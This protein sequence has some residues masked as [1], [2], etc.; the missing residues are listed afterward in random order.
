M[1][2]WVGSRKLYRPDL[3]TDAVRAY[4]CS[5]TFGAGGK[6]V[7]DFYAKLRALRYS[8]F[9][10][11]DFEETGWGEL[12]WLAKKTP[13]NVK[14]C[15]N[16]VEELTRDLEN[17]RK[18]AKGNPANEFFVERVYKGWLSYLVWVN[19]DKIR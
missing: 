7:Y 16:L 19:N 15:A 3:D 14:G 4:Y 11:T 8:E 12:G 1:E 10:D 5:R 18:A 2:M 6:Y 17:A 9:R 13:S